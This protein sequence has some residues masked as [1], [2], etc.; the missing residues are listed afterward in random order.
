MSA[1]VR[2][3]RHVVE[4]RHDVVAM[5]PVTLKAARTILTTFRQVKIACYLSIALISFDF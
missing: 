2:A 3:F 5:E 4:T 1:F